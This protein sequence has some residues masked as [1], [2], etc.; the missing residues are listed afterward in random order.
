[1]NLPDIQLPPYAATSETAVKFTVYPAT[2]ISWLPLVPT[3]LLL[4]PLLSGNAVSP[5]VAVPAADGGSLPAG[6]AACR[7]ALECEQSEHDA[8]PS[9]AG[10]AVLA[11]LLQEQG[12][13]TPVA[14]VPDTPCHAW[15]ECW[16]YSYAAVTECR[17]HT[18]LKVCVLDLHFHHVKIAPVT[19]TQQP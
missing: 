5:G 13:S 15:G 12:G 6:P 7:P 19:P 8:G 10:G 4:L 18:K 9:K 1:V 16:K 14:G 17:T 2:S 3:L 11:A